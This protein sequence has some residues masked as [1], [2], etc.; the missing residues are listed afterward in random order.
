MLVLEY[1]LFPQMIVQTDSTVSE[2]L[3]GSVG[4]ESREPL[5]AARVPERDDC[6]AEFGGW[7]KRER[8]RRKIGYEFS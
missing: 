5:V 7:R 2:D 6:G 4:T 3:K 1:H 8:R